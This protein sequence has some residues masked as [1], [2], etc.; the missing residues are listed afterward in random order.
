MT[1][2]TE[3]DRPPAENP[4]AGSLPTQPLTV[5]SV[6]MDTDIHPDMDSVRADM[7]REGPR[8]RREAKHVYRNPTRGSR[9]SKLS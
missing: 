5:R 4:D 9:S 1:D 2:Q 6:K 7:L 3:G 8:S